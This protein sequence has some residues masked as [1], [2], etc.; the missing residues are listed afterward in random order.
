M[1]V[2]NPSVLLV[3]DNPD[4]ADLVRIAMDDVGFVCRL[5]VA[6]DGA[7]A[8]RFIRG[9]DPFTDRPWPHLVL[10]DLN[11]PDI[12]G[13]DVLHEI[14]ADPTYASIPVIVMTTSVDDNDVIASYGDHA[15]AFVSKPPNF[16]ELVDLVERI[17][18][19]WFGVARLP[20]T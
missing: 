18:G 10:L 6:R 13:R 17:V 5:T 14:K 4:D 9:E 20:R 2:E 15:N 11:L 12:D 1:A 8:L 7:E 3:E 16:D 19:F